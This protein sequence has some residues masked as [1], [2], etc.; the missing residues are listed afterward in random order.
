MTVAQRSA[1][2]IMD[3]VDVA[4][5]VIVPVLAVAVVLLVVRDRIK[6]WR[7]RRQ[8]RRTPSTPI[9]ALPEHQIGRIVGCI[10]ASEQALTAPVSGR[11]CAYYAVV[12]SVYSNRSWQKRATDRSQ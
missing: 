7:I 6:A 5:W 3:A 11:P 1:E 2:Q 9:A 4:S 8:H 10:T 12:I